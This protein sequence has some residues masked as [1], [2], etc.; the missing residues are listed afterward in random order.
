MLVSD[1]GHSSVPIYWVDLCWRII[2]Y[3]R[4]CVSS[5][6]SSVSNSLIGRVFI[7]EYVF[8]SVV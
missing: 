6:I 5:F 8:S 4:S 2:Y 1:L 7:S 3:F